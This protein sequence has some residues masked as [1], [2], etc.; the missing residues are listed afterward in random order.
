MLKLT[1]TTLFF[2]GC[3]VCLAKDYRPNDKIYFRQECI[4]IEKGQIVIRDGDR[5]VHAHVLRRDKK[6]FFA[7][8]RETRKM[9]FVLWGD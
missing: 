3:G 1:A 9:R 5:E 7:Y 4:S 6:G 8:Y 2:L